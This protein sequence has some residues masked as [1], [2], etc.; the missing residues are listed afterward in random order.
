MYDHTYDVTGS[1]KVKS[2][3][4]KV[5]LA[6]CSSTGLDKF[7]LYLFITGI[8][9]AHG[10]CTPGV[11]QARRLQKGD[12]KT[13]TLFCLTMVKNGRA[14]TLPF[15]SIW[16]AIW[17]RPTLG[18][19]WD[20][21]NADVAFER[22]ELCS[23]P[24]GG[25]VRVAFRNC[26]P[27]P[28]I[29]CWLNERGVPHHYY[30][31]PP[32]LNIGGPICS[33]D[34]IETSCVGHAFCIAKCDD[35]EKAK[36]EGIVDTVVGAYR[37]IIEGNEEESD[38]PY[39]HLVTISSG[40]TTVC[41]AAAKDF[42][43]MAELGAVDPTP[44]DT[45][46]KY[47]GKT[48]LGGWP[49]RVEKNWHGGNQK[50]K[51]LFDEHLRT[52]TKFLPPHAREGLKKNTP[53]FIN[54]SQSYGPAVCPV[55]GRGMCFHPD[56]SWLEQNGMC[57]DK[58]ECIEVYRCQE[59]E[60]DCDQWGPGG[61]LLH[62]LC[63]AYHWKMVPGGYDNSEIKKCYQL[64]MREGLYNRVKVHGSQ[65]PTG[66]AYACENEMEY[67]A[68]LSVAFLAGQ[69]KDVEYNKWQPFNRH[70][71]KIFDPRAFKLLQRIWKVDCSED[72]EDMK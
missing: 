65:G 6:I 2:V 50:L 35:V 44:L 62:E 31:L 37:P 30:E 12:L 54:K 22:G 13:L 68:E 36:A 53:F 17:P 38:G 24:A 57:K 49:V 28:L 29:L 41:C 40:K 42:L 5:V 46:D 10:L 27:L 33:S 66:R 67:F 55:K 34:H 18:K 63:H 43:V 45:T 51:H 11:Q 3:T 48:T 58:V 26:T 9:R 69:D 21:S 16:R 8:G 64:A 72:D 15:D 52:A 70:E 7:I 20:S 59:Y 47:Y 61:V 60:T 19:V 14:W 71:L 4:S 25:P 23:K 56:D 32:S 1:H 39:I